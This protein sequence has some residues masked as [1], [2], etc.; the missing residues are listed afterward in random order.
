MKVNNNNNNTEVNKN[1]DTEGLR[2]KL[3]AVGIF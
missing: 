3:Y 1:S 2:I